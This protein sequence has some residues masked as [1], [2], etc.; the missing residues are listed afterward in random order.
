MPILMGID[1][2]WQEANALWAEAAHQSPPTTSIDGL[3]IIQPLPTQVGSGYNRI[4][5]LQL[6]MEL[7]IFSDTFHDCTL[8][9]PKNQHPLQFTVYL[10]DAVEGANSPNM[11]KDFGLVSGSGMQRSWSVF[12][13]AL[14]LWLRSMF[15]SSHTYWLSFLA[16]LPRSNPMSYSRHPLKMTGKRCFHPRQLGPCERSCTRF[17]NILFQGSSK[18]QYP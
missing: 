17:S 14:S 9:M 8:R 13:P 7:H 2:S 16:R 12:S 15:K 10:S 18:R 5:E 4:I 1:L 11:N 6:E 3:E